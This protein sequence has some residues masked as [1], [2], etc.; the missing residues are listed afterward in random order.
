MRLNRLKRILPEKLKAPLRKIY[1]KNLKEK[2]KK[3]LFFDE[4]KLNVCIQRNRETLNSVVTWVDQ[5]AIENSVYG[6]GVNSHIIELL[7]KPIN[8]EKTYTDVMSYF[9]NELFLS[10]KYLELG[11]SVGKNFYQILNCSDKIESVHGFD[12]E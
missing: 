3:K 8:N 1:L 7:D 9:I 6:Y 11:V 10:V 12:I 5:N 4:Q 2:P